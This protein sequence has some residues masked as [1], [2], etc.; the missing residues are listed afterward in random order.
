MI[1]VCL[2]VGFSFLITVFLVSIYLFGL[3][4][5]YGGSIYFGFS[6]GGDGDEG[7]IIEVFKG[8]GRKGFYLLSVFVRSIGKVSIR[9]DYDSDD[10]WFGF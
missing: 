9:G 3:S 1:L 5:V 2:I 6:L 8:V 10:R 4:G 7:V